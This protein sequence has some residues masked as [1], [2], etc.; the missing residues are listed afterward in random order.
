MQEEK[1]CP[2]C[3]SPLEKEQNFYMC[4]NKSC[5]YVEYDDIEFVRKFCL[6]K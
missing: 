2:K 5:S 3:N 1:K 4:T 6:K